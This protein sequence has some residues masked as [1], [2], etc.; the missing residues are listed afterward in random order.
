LHER[1][2]MH[3]AG[4]RNQAL[5]GKCIDDELH[6]DEDYNEE[7]YKKIVNYLNRKYGAGIDEMAV[8]VP[9]TRL[10]EV[11]FS[12]GF[13]RWVSRENKFSLRLFHSALESRQPSPYF[14]EIHCQDSINYDQLLDSDG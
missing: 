13:F 1:L 4:V 8:R 10:G 7:I 12:S 6:S 14:E 9:R 3:G 5:H 11:E 2:F